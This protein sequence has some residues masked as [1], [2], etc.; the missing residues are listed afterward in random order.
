[1]SCGTPVVVSNRGAIPELV[2]GQG[3]FVD[4]NDPQSV[5]AG[6]TNLLSKSDAELR[7]IG[8][9]A[10][11]RIVEHFSYEQRRAAIQRVIEDISSLENR[12]DQR[13]MSA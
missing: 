7:E 5:A 4:H 11:N 10:R 3:F 2:N 6:I 1:M 13:E 8:E 12:H 9:K